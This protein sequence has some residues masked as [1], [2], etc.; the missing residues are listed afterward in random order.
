[1]QEISVVA[2][3]NHVLKN[4]S[5]FTKMLINAGGAAFIRYSIVSFLNLRFRHMHAS[6]IFIYL[7]PTSYGRKHDFYLRNYFYNNFIFKSILH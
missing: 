7:L 3:M 6:P 1:M 2:E 5:I 4:R